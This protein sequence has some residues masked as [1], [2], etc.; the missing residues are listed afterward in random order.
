LALRDTWTVVG[1]DL[2]LTALEFARQRNMKLLTS[3]DVEALPFASGTFDA[4]LSCDVLEHVEH[5]LTALCEMYR[6]TKRG[7][8]LVVTAPALPSLWSDHDEALGHLRRYTKEGLQKKL[9]EAGWKIEW[10]N[11]TVTLLMPP[12]A[13]FRLIRR[14]RRRSGAPTVDLFEMPPLINALLGATCRLDGWLAM[15]LPLPPGA[16][17]LA[18]GRKAS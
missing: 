8:I 1:V 15:R 11:Y 4:V 16:S 18:I 3:G 13:V 9:A 6:V 12:I 17:L 14:L 2:S 7:G 5:D 10:L